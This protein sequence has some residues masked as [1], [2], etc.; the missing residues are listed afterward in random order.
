V[1]L[2]NKKFHC[3]EAEKETRS[4]D[5]MKKEKGAEIIGRIAD[6][7]FDN[8]GLDHSENMLKFEKLLGFKTAQL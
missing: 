8:S 4:K 2:L 6:I 7:N 1:L 5:L 3:F